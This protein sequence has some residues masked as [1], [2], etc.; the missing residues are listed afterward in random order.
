[1]PKIIT[2]QAQM[3]CTLGAKPEKLS[4]TSQ[5]YIKIAGGLVATEKDKEPMVN[6]PSFGNCKCN[7]YNPPCVPSPQAWQKTTVKDSVDGMKKLTKDSTSMCSKG[8]TISFIDTGKNT[9][10]DGE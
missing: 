9:F 5:T 2:E 4:V 8:G 6:I 1:M 10:V 7:P 3:K